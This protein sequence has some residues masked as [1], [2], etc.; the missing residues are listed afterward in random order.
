MIMQVQTKKDAELIKAYAETGDEGAFAEIVSRYGAMVYSVCFRKLVNQHDAKDASQAVFMTLV[1]KSCH[2][3]EKKTL[4]CWLYAVARQTALFMARSRV[5]RDKRESVAAEIMNAESHS[6]VG[7]HDSETILGILDEGLSA[8]SVGQREAVILRHLQ[9]LSEKD[10]AEIAECAPG[11]LSKRAFDGILTLRKRLVKRGCTLGVPALIGVLATESQAAIP[12]TLIPSLL[13]VPKLAAAVAAAGS[14]AGSIVSIMEGT[15]KVMFMTKMKMVGLGLLAALLLMLLGSGIIRVVAKG[16]IADGGGKAVVS[17]ADAGTVAQAPDSKS[18]PPSVR[19]SPKTRD[20]QSEAER[21]LQGYPNDLEPLSSLMREWFDYAPDVAVSWAEHMPKSRAQATALWAVA[22]AWAE[23][24]PLW[25]AEWAE[26]LP[27]DG[28]Y[29]NEYLGQIIGPL[30]GVANVWARK[31]PEAALKW[32]TQINKRINEQRSSKAMENGTGTW[33]P[34]KALRSAVSSW[35]QQ[36]PVA[37]AEW[38]E[39]Q[40]DQLSDSNQTVGAVVAGWA[41][42]DMAA[43]INWVE[44]LPGE[45]QELAMQDVWPR[46]CDDKGCPAAADWFS[47]LPKRQMRDWAL[48]C[49][50]S[51]WVNEDPVAVVEWAERLPVEER[52]AT[53]GDLAYAWAGK[54]PEAAANWAEQLPKEERD[55]TLSRVSDSWT[56]KDPVGAANWAERL[57]EGDREMRLCQIA[58]VWAHK[59]PMAAANWAGQMTGGEGR[60]KAFEAVADSLSFVSS[61]R[62]KWVNQSSLSDAV[63]AELLKKIGEKE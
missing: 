5:R 30:D 4:A 21:A 3:K 32:A 24:D 12:E 34:P 19:H 11:T 29:A 31:D 54:D 37:A 18:T 38:A 50:V 25:A 53:L 56:W 62:A 10:A 58:R 23:K 17:D 26:N 22:E 1:K 46:L 13:A 60:D 51:R 44:R 2:L 8:L 28:E 42:N 47:Q 40:E 52:N 57:P 39:Q 49:V 16:K 6:Y 20:F 63:K 33:T 41:R 14:G 45:K 9:G 36:D 15:M 43:A 55:A 35:A 61:D 27:F 59:D 48:G 7:S